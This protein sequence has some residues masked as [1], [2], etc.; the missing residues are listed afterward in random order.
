MKKLLKDA[1]LASLGLVL[2][3]FY[4]ISIHQ[5]LGRRHLDPGR[6]QLSRVGFFVGFYHYPIRGRGS[7][8][9][10]QSEA[11]ILLL[12][13]IGL[14]LITGAGYNRILVWTCREAKKYVSVYF[15]FNEVVVFYFNVFSSGLIN[16][17]KDRRT[18]LI[19][20][21]NNFYYNQGLQ[22]GKPP[23]YRRARTVQSFHKC[24]SCFCAA[25]TLS[26]GW[27]IR[28]SIHS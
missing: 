26:I 17:S 15:F 21:V 8:Y 28:T 4:T 14:I 18:S 25:A 27:S 6:I 23:N 12:G 10:S 1:S 2:L 22:S 7:S 20:S 16:T 9:V 24:T 11:R 13:V 3:I 5:L 19:G